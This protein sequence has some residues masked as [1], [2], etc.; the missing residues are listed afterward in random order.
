MAVARVAVVVDVDQRH[1]RSVAPSGGISV[2]L[3]EGVHNIKLNAEA[4]APARQGK[5]A[6]RRDTAH[7]AGGRAVVLFIP[8]WRPQRYPP[9]VISTADDDYD[10]LPDLIGDD[11]FFDRCMVRGI[12]HTKDN[13]YVWTDS[14]NDVPGSGASIDG[15]FR[16]AP[17][18]SSALQKGEPYAN[19]D[20]FFLDDEFKRFTSSYD[21]A[22]TA[23]CQCACHLEARYFSPLRSRPRGSPQ[24]LGPAREIVKERKGA[25]PVIL[26]AVA[27]VTYVQ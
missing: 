15:T 6:P 2:F 21:S 3:A 16:L 1:R 19:Y 22:C 7:W 25:G 18:G 10:D 20:F 14:P 27:A 17:K 8:V 13:V 12:V 4:F 11:E 5:S 23:V 26:D 24:I 9:P